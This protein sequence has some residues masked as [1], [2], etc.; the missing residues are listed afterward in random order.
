MPG[1][2]G[3]LGAPT[4]APAQPLTA[5]LPTGPGPG[6]EA[7]NVNIP[8]FTPL[9]DLKALYRVE[10]LEEIRKIIQYAEEEEARQASAQRPR[11]P[12]FEQLK[13]L[14]GGP[15]PM[16]LPDPTFDAASGTVQSGKS[17]YGRKGNLIEPNPPGTFRV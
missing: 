1:Q 17:V 14:H 4:N 6:P 10:P 8:A 9:D 15:A 2:H 11:R 7:L 12:S 5:G 13:L 16:G 3:P